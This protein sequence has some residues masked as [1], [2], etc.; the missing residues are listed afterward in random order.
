[1]NVLTRGLP[2]TGVALL[3]TTAG[4][5][6]DVTAQQVWDDW[7][8]SMTILP[9]LTVTAGSESYANGVLT[10]TDF[11]LASVND[12]G[13]M[14]STL[15]ELVFTEQSDG[16][17]AVTMA[18]VQ[19]I[20]FRNVEDWGTGTHFMRMTVTQTDAVTTVSGEPGAMQYEIAI[21]RAVFSLDEYRQD[22]E[23]MPA[24]LDF[25]LSDV[26]GDFSWG[27][28]DEMINMAYSF[29]I[30]RT[31]M[32]AA[33][34]PLEGD[35]SFSANGS[36]ADI[37][38]NAV[39]AVPAGIDS[40]DGAAAFEAG[41]MIDSSAESG[42]ASIAFSVTE[43]GETTKASLALDNSRNR[44][45]MDRMAIAYDLNFAGLA[46]DVQSDEIPFPVAFSAGEVG[47]GVLVPVGAGAEPAPFSGKVTLADLEVS[48]ELWAMVDA[49]GIIPRDPATAVIDVSGTATL[50]RSLYEDD[51]MEGTEP[52]GMFNT[53]DINTVDLSFGG[54]TA[55]A[56]G[57][58]TFDLASAGKFDGMPMP[59]GRVDIAISGV[60]S[61]MQKLGQIGLLPPEQ[62]MG[63]TMMLGMFAVPSGE[64]AMTSS[65]EIDASGQVTANGMPL[66]F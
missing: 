16:T 20:E 23:I 26:S 52:P 27:Q 60:N 13:E 28:T 6:A 53:V 15:P 44:L 19:T 38:S 43:F 34:A 54:A 17:V 12:E 1:M 64:D 3:M 40:D 58:F 8:A 46:V 11:V 30:A 33:L 65:I 62:A 55:H 48:D 37:R 2:M 42:A 36:V 14:R 49:G 66:P 7:K 5:F 18:P 63:V 4:A 56:D 47:L 57:G 24:T 41:L 32:K 50:T 29:A 22:E 51:I 61:L 10:V 59:E 45:S 39:M 35:E 9:D 21:P 25:V 31:D